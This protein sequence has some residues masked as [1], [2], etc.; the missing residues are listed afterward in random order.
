MDQG[1]GNNEHRLDKTKFRIPLGQK[2]DEKMRKLTLLSSL[3]VAVLVLG[4]SMNRPA[5]AE[6]SAVGS[7]AVSSDISQATSSS[8]ALDPEDVD[9]ALDAKR[10]RIGGGRSHM[11][12]AGRHIG[13]HA[14]HLGRPVGHHGR[15]HGLRPHSRIAHHPG[16]HRHHI[17]HP[18]HH[19]R[20]PMGLVS[21]I[22]PEV[23][24]EETECIG[25]PT[26]IRPAVEIEE[27]ECTQCPIR[28]RPICR[29]CDPR[30]TE[31]ETEVLDQELEQEER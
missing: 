22:Q 19:H 9:S 14:G 16:H 23:E 2:G 13:R 17:H 3:A 29:V 6:Q 12:P 20:L 25:C 11:R 18:R 7:D 15:H 30:E 24:I 8:L 5:A 1:Q 31:V 26:I 21:W 10:G 28:T 4:L 27:T